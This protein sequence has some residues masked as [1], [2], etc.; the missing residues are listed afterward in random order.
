MVYSM[1]ILMLTE[2]FA[3]LPGVSR[4]AR[5]THIAVSTSWRYA[6]R[7]TSVEN[8]LLICD[9]CKG[10]IRG[11]P[12]YVSAKAVHFGCKEV[13]ERSNEQLND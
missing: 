3:F 12:F 6:A 2:I 11:I 7:K 13:S 8:T 9:V 4:L 1:G 10:I 5:P